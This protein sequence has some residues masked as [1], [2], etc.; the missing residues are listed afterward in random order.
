MFFMI[1]SPWLNRIIPK[2][3]NKWGLGEGLAGGGQPATEAAEA[4]DEW[5]RPVHGSA[6]LENHVIII[7]YQQ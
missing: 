1:F 3:T 7:A 6:A 2:K 5:R 4:L